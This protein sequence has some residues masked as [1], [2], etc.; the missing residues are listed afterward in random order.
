MSRCNYC[1]RPANWAT[2]DVITGERIAECDVF[3]GCPNRKKVT[4]GGKV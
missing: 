4:I 3:W 2:V 1:G